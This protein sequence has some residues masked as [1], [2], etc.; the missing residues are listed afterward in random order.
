MQTIVEALTSAIAILHPDMFVAIL[1][2]SYRIGIYR[3]QRMQRQ[4]NHVLN[5]RDEAC[6]DELSN[7]LHRNEPV[8][9]S[10]CGSIQYIHMCNDI[11][12]NVLPIFEDNELIQ[13]V[14]PSTADGAPGHGGTLR[15]LKTEEY[16]IR[17]TIAISHVIDFFEAAYRVGDYRDS[18]LATI[19]SMFDAFNPLRLGKDIG[20]TYVPEVMLGPSLEAVVE[21][22]FDEDSNSFIAGSTSQNDVSA[23]R[24][25]RQSR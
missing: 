3:F 16:N 12:G 8:N 5:N 22:I 4:R 24:D 9:G 25:I 17:P 18:I 20:Q 21:W 2:F 1:T 15:L 14:A 7:D 10:V 19:S 13:I 23:P 11:Q 6:D